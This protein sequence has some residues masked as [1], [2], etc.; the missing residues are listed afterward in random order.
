MMTI[1]LNLEQLAELKEVLEDEF[2]V[3]ITT[4]LQDAELRQQMITAAIQSKDYNEVRLA[5]HSLKGASAN[6]G[7]LMLAE[8]CEH[9]EHDCRAGHYD[10]CEM[11]SQKIG[12]EF[13]I[14]RRELEMLV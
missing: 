6:L 11:Y 13:A 3:L 14:V 9:L 1:H 8:V 4:Y 12:D 2:S 7:A 5:A 10:N